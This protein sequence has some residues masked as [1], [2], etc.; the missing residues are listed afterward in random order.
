VP[1]ALAVLAALAVAAAPGAP[2]RPDTVALRFAWRTP[3]E[4]RVAYRRTVAQEGRPPS[5]FTARFTTRAERDG[6][7]IRIASR[8]TGWS[9]DAPFPPGFA[10]QALRASEQVVEVLDARGAFAGLEGTEAMRPVLAKIFAL[11]EVP[12]EQA[13][14]A[15][16]LA[17]AAMRT[18]TEQLWNLQAGFWMGAELEVGRTY[19]MEGEAPVPL[20]PGLRAR[21]EMRFSA[22]RRV[23]CGAGERE[24]RCVELTL[25]TS[26]DAGALASA[27]AA[28]LP[29]LAGAGV[30]IPPDE[31]REIAAEAEALVVTEPAT[32]LPHRL[33]WTKRLRATW[34]TP[35][36]LA[37]A[38]REERSEYEW[39]YEGAG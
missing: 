4:A 2:R 30:S 3:L 10:D 25:R 37:T 1:I 19:A 38:E 23:P 24:A 35:D 16:E 20:A 39:R 32:L 15:V 12:R 28:I 7:R 9:G 36:G 6:E 21:Q 11:A 27:A 26:S 14:R 13:A 33:V 22:R 18:E 5:V 17:E 31:V 8:D 29:S 34:G